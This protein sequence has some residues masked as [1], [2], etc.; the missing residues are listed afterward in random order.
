MSRTSDDQAPGRTNYRAL[1]LSLGLCFG[2]ALGV[3][4]GIVL[5]NLAFMSIGIGGGMCPGLAIGAGLAARQEENDGN[6]G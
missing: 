3:V 4:F 5:D 1:G 6:E 2:V